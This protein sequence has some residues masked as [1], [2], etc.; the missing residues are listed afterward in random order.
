MSSIDTEH[1]RLCH[2]LF[3]AIE[4][5]DIDASLA[6]IDEHIDSFYTEVE[7]RVDDGRGRAGPT[8]VSQV[9]P[10]RP[11]AVRRHRGTLY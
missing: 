8:Y 11:V 1:R 7:L 6:A 9:R 2:A 5:G 3:D 10:A 4:A